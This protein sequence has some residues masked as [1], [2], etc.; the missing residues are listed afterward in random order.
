MTSRSKPRCL[1]L[2]C[3]AGGAS[4]GYHL[5]GF[6]VVGVDIQPQPHYPFDF[7]QSD[8]LV[9]LARS[10]QDFD[11]I[12]ASPPCQSYSRRTP[13]P[14]RQ[15][16]QDLI[17]LTRQALRQTGKPFVIE[18]VPGSPLQNYLVLHGSMFELPIF[19][20]RWFECNP[21]LCFAPF[22]PR[23]DFVPVP[24]LGSSSHKMACKADAE[25]ALQ[26]TW[27]NRRELRQAVPPAY[28]RF[29][30]LQMLRVLTGL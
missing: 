21:M 1:D 9:H 22:S 16:H 17:E 10:F 8:A 11:L 29:I 24:L 25:W 15:E 12:H 6:E 13:I 28:T 4:M 27:M 5:A 14:F 7:V 19:R 26:I 20:E 30:G 2:Y 23:E 18:N 3:K